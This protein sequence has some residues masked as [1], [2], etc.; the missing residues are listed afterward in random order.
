MVGHSGEVKIT[1][2]RAGIRLVFEK[3]RLVEIEEW[4]PE[5]TL[6]S[7]DAGFPDLIFTQ[8]LFGYRDLSEL[9][10]AFADC[11]AKDDQVSLLLD[12]LFPK[13]ASQVWPVS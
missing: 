12:I 1:F 9:K 4:E 5:P 11:W 7:G 8:L 10:Y 13:R 2:Y 6:K 3:G